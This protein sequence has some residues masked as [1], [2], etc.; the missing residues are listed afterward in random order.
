MIR[1]SRWWLASG[2]T[3]T[4][5]LTALTVGAQQ[6]DGKSRDGQGRTRGMMMGGMMMG[7]DPALMILRSDQVQKELELM[8]D[9]K[10][11][12][13]ALAD[14]VRE[15]FQK[16][17]AGVRDMA[18]EERA[19]KMLEMREKLKSRTEE[20]RAKVESEILLPHQVDRLRQL[21]LQARG[22]TALIDAR[23]LQEL[24]VSDAQKERL[25]KLRER[26]EQE[27]RSMMNQGNDLRN[28]NEEQRRA[29]MGEMRARV[30]KLTKEITDDALS[31]LTPQQKEK[32]EKMQGKK[33]DFDT[34]SR[35]PP[36]D[37]PS[38][39]TD[40]KSEK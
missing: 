9:Q 4:A 31:V 1:N 19:V 15:E 14:Q 16:E 35:R 26:M 17:F 29:R 7:V 34:P 8:D 40:Q 2:V 27:R 36:S 33:F 32:L 10:E 21:G 22:A 25:A 39:K 37:Q 23:V 11:K 30:E 20:I 6:D 5:V 28:M 13:K 3:L 38:A 12:L 24:G 18:P